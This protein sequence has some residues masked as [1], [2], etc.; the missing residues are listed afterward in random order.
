MVGRSNWGG[1]RN[2]RQNESESYEILKHSHFHR[3][4]K[5]PFLCVGGEFRATK[6]RNEK[7][8]REDG[9]HLSHPA[10]CTVLYHHVAPAEVNEMLEEAEG[11]GRAVV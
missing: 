1:G 5:F 3:C 9:V 8:R 11:G 7:H 10:V 2:R 4:W 6:A